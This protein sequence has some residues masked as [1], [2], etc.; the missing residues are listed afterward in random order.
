[1]AEF[2]SDTIGMRQSAPCEPNDLRT[3]IIRE[4]VAP[5]GSGGDNRVEESVILGMVSGVDRGGESRKPLPG[6]LFVNPAC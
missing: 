4:R 1:M 6:F 2:L 3:D 5:S